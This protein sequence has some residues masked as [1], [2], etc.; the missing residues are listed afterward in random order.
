MQ[1]IRILAK[2]CFKNIFLLITVT[3]LYSQNR[4][5]FIQ[6]GPFKVAVVKTIILY[7]IKDGEP[8]GI[9]PEILH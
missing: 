2:P 7:Y 6:N 3:L 8:K 4:S 9:V 1:S 5:T